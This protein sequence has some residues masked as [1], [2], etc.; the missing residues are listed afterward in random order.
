MTATDLES[1]TFEELIAEFDTPWV[2]KIL[3][4]KNTMDYVVAVFMKHF[5]LEYEVAEAKMWEVHRQGVSTLDSGTEEE[6]LI[7]HEAMRAYGLRSSVEK[8]T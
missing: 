1:T 4:D 7:H 6:M 5:K 2:I 3:D 8:A